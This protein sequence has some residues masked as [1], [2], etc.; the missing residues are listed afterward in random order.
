MNTTTEKIVFDSAL[1]TVRE[2][3][4]KVPRDEAIEMYRAIMKAAKEISDKHK[5]NFERK[6]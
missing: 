4:K 5:F 6:K 3:P 1:A 2:V